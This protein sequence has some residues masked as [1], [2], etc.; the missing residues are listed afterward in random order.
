MGTDPSL[1]TETFVSTLVI[2]HRCIIF[3][4]L[5]RI[6]LL[7]RTNTSWCDGYWEIPG[8]KLEHGQEF[9]HVLHDEVFQETGLRV[10]KVSKLSYVD[11]FNLTSG[12]YK[13]HHYLEIVRCALSYSGKLQISEEHSAFMWATK[14]KA[15]S[16][17]LTDTTRRALLALL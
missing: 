14:R 8:G 12:K 7:K 11:A 1:L 4:K 9:N 5:N 3:D 10:R 13:G 2:V 15:L 6:L 16:L 17:K